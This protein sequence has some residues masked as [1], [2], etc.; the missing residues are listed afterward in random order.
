MWQA[1]RPVGRYRYASPS[2]ITCPRFNALFDS[3]HVDG[4]NA[5]TQERRGAVSF[6]LSNYHELEIN[7][8]ST[9]CDDAPAVIVVPEW[10]YQAW[11]RRLHP[12]PGPGASRPGSTSAAQP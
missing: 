3:V 8:S 6:V 4:A 2:N 9:E 10:P 7:L 5:L 1:L 12:A 11:W